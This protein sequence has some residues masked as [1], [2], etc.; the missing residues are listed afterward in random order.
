MLHR[1]NRE[2][3]STGTSGI[4]NLLTKKRKKKVSRVC[5][6]IFGNILWV[7]EESIITQS[8]V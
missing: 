7:L 2:E 1:Y 5:V 4:A 6:T 8:Q 3:Y